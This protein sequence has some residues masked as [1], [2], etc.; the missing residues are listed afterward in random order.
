MDDLKNIA[1]ELSKLEKE[2]PFGVPEGYFDKFPARLKIR[3]DA[4][5]K[6]DTKKIRFIQVL[7]PVVGLAASFALIFM[8]V[9]WPLKTFTPDQ[10]AE[11]SAETEMTD[12]DYMSV[13]ERIDEDSF[14][15]LLDE[16]PAEE[17]EFSDEE[18]LAY[19]SVNI[20]EYEMYADDE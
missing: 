16:Q 20:S 17:I 19:V 6:T 18:L 7:K 14:F 1:P 3:M 9:Y 13:L 5:E 4:E 12:A 15:A 11:N 8:L 10:V 2:N